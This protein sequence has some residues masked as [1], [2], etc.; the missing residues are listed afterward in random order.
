MQKARLEAFRHRFGN[1]LYDT[2]CAAMHAATFCEKTISAI[3]HMQENNHDIKGVRRLIDLLERRKR[4]L[5]Y[6]KCKDFQR[7]TEIIH[8]YKVK[9]VITGLHKKH[10]HLGDIHRKMGPR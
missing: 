4:A 3:K 6:L 2:G 1:G 9:D 8:Y 7:Y 5:V 10:F